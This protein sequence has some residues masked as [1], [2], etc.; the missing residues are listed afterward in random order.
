[1]KHGFPR[2]SLAVDEVS[3]AGKTVGRSRALQECLHRLSRRSLVYP[4]GVTAF[5]VPSSDTPTI[6][7]D[8][9]NFSTAASLWRK[10]GEDGL[11]VKGFRP[12]CERGDASH[13]TYIAVLRIPLQ[14]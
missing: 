14:I 7:K 9:M 2:E 5:M 11:P 6:C 1:M 13:M 10:E 8:V 3:V 4:S 12:F